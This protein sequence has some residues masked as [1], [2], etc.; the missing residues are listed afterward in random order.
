MHVHNVRVY[1]GQRSL[2]VHSF[3]CAV[4][5]LNF[6]IIL[7]HTHTHSC[8][9]VS[10]K[11]YDVISAKPL[12]LER[13]KS[14]LKS[15]TEKTRKPSFS[16]HTNLGGPREALGAISQ[17]TLQLHSNN[18]PSSVPSLSY[19]AEQ[20]QRHRPCPTCGSRARQLNLRRTVC[21]NPACQ[22][23]FCQRCFRR[24]HEG[25]CVENRG[26]RSPPKRGQSMLVACSL[27]SKKRLRRL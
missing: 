25:D 26:T 10:R 9:Q 15:L 27:K 6:T 19:K 11:W 3:S 18:F 24:W 1:F 21:T 13:I 12:Y 5:P 8:L 14:H 16:F 4:F 23:D 7:L 20:T 2:C 17:N 22:L